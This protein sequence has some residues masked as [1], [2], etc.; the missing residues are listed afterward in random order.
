MGSQ[1]PQGVHQRIRALRKGL[2][3]QSEALVPHGRGP[4][5]LRTRIK[6]GDLSPPAARRPPMT[7]WWSVKYPWP[8]RHTRTIGF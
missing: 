5:A 4:L 8:R 6:Y 3:P 1:G 2:I 7:T